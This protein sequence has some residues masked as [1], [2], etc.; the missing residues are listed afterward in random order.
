MKRIVNHCS[1][2]KT[3]KR[4]SKRWLKPEDCIQ[5]TSW[6]DSSL[7]SQ[8]LVYAVPQTLRKLISISPK[9]IYLVIISKHYL[10][11]GLYKALSSCSFIIQI[12][13]L[14]DTDSERSSSYKD[15]KVVFYDDLHLILMFYKESISHLLDD[16][17]LPLI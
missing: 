14:I 9:D 11:S 2:A 12:N 4:R 8:I 5:P 17:F 13:Y 3:I 1:S 15:F 7:I 16:T 10:V 6:S